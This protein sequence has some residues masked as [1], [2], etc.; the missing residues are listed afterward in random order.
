[1]ATIGRTFET[2]DLNSN[3]PKE[4]KRRDHALG[5]VLGV[6]AHAMLE[7]LQPYPG[8]ERLRDP[9]RCNQTRFEVVRVSE[10]DYTIYDAYFL[11]TTVLPV[12][13]LLDPTFHIAV[14]YAWK[15]VEAL[16]F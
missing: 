14:W 11:H 3:V 12:D 10:N 9:S 15:R 16:E 2:L 8:D 5:D 13:L 4:V 1:M 6:C 7:F